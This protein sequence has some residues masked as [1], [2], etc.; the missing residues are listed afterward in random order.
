MIYIRE[1]VVAE[2]EQYELIIKEWV[3]KKPLYEQNIKRYTE[4]IAAL[5]NQIEDLIMGKVTD[6]SRSEYYDSMIKKRENEI[7]ELGQKISDSQKYDEVSRQKRDSLKSTSELLS[8]II[9]SGYVSDAN[10][11]MLLKEVKVFN[12]EDGGI[13]VV[14]EFNGDFN[15]R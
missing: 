2:S 12:D 13:D 9:S 7:A 4:K 5:K 3:K 11:R 15:R 6:K 14:L 1:K 10:L 8:E